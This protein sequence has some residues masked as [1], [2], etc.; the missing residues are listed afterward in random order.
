MRLH[1]LSLFF[2]RIQ[3]EFVTFCFCIINPNGFPMRTKF[4]Q[5]CAFMRSFSHNYSASN[6]LYKRFGGSFPRK[7]FLR[8]ISGSVPW[9]YG[10]RISIISSHLS[11]CKESFPS[12]N[13]WME[14][15]N[16]A[17]TKT[18]DHYIMSIHPQ[19]NKVQ[20]FG[21]LGK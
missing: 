15:S 12:E 8:R 17:N 18:F 9:K 2:V 14:I 4:V 5:L 21:L 19:H 7:I 20:D 3:T 6:F 16:R 1:L 13:I 10:C 11:C